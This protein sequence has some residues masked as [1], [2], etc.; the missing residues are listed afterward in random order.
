MMEAYKN[1]NCCIFTL[2]GILSLILGIPLGIVLGIITAI[3][4]I[5][6]TFLR[7]PLNF[8]KTYK[9]IIINELLGRRLKFLIL[10]SLTIIQ[11][12][13]PI[14]AV[15]A[16]VP[17]SIVVLCLLF[18]KHIFEWELYEFVTIWKKIPSQYWK[19][20]VEFYDITLEK[21]NHPTRVPVNWNGVLY[22][23][24]ELSL[25]RTVMGMV[26]TICGLITGF[27]G[28][29]FIMMTKF[30]YL[31]FRG[32]REYL[33]TIPDVCKKPGKA[34]ILLPFWL[35]GFAVMIG[36]MPIILG[37]GILC[38]PLVGLHCTYIAVKHNFNLN[39]VFKEALNLMIKLDE[40]TGGFKVTQ[41]LHLDMDYTQHWL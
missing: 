20:H 28:L 19:E 12:G 29:S 13:Y 40:L 2:K 24:P 37:L 14:I 21:Y 5:A 26:L 35:M 34:I 25:R 33:K 11:L 38:S 17:I 9:V 36:L 3:G 1:D 41:N 18:V 23:I 8:Y 32:I 6:I 16:A 10:L 30:P 4:L 27:V 7:Y 22:D 39:H 31:F 15:I